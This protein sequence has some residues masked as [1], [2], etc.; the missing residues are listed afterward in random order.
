MINKDEAIGLTAH[1]IN[2]MAALVNT[3]FIFFIGLSLP[4]WGIAAG[5][6]FGAITAGVNI[7]SKRRLVKIAEKTGR[8][9]L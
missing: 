5:I 3:V 7:W 9:S 8:V 1:I 4:D 2:W 6:L